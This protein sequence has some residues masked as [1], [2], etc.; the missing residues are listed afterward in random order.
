MTTDISDQAWLRGRRLANSIVVAGCLLICLR[1]TLLLAHVAVVS[2][3]SAGL[4]DFAQEWTSARNYAIGQPIY[5]DFGRSLAI[6]FGPAPAAH[7][8]YNAHPPV[9]SPGFA[10]SAAALP[11]RISDVSVLS[12]ACLVASLLMVLRN[13]RGQPIDLP[14]LAAI[15]LVMTS[16]VLMQQTIQGQLNLVLLVLIT[17]AW[18]ADQKN[19]PAAS[20]SI[21]WDRRRDQALSC[22]SG[23]VLCR[24]AEVAALCGESQLPS[25]PSTASA[26]SCLASKR[27]ATTFSIA[28][29][30]AKFRDTWPNASLLGF[31]S[32]LFDGGFVAGRSAVALPDL[33]QHR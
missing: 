17:G 1:A 26:A 16:S 23:F 6:H 31:W 8:Q 27:T 20:G 15:T 29:D 5:L 24:P 13:R 12:A 2:V 30:V 7:F 14:L 11:T 28:P 32:K 33:G 3:C 21:D 19:L 9:R 25:W 4:F 10:F 22:L 18:L